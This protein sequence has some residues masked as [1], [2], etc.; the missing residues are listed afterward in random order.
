MNF[1]CPRCKGELK[2]EAPDQLRCEKE[3]LD[4][5][6]SDGVWHFL[7][8]ERESHYSRFITEY[9]AV[10]RLEGRFSGDAAY[11]RALPFQDLSGRFSADW[12]IRAAS[13]LALTKILPE[14]STILDLGAGNCW[15]SNRLSSRGH[16]VYA[17]D[18][19]TNP[20]DG[21]GAWR[22]YDAKF[23]A[24]QAEFVFL[25]FSNASVDV[26][27]FNASLHYAES[28]E[29]TFTEALRVLQP[30]GMLVVM[31]SPVY[32]DAS[33]GQKMLDERKT[34]F[35]SRYGFASDSIQSKGFLTYKRMEELGNKLGIHWQ[36]IVPF[37]GLRWAVRPLL[38]R[39]RGGREPAQFGLWLG[40]R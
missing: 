24:T 36:H 2:F 11:Y 33:S 40:R 38:A 34:Q 23:T 16:D 30:K 7:L 9:E 14:H 35:L 13:F 20:D 29:Q 12:K 19:L 18:L 21:L 26:V 17:V 22:N 8:P 37:Y 6:Q 27:I 10:R 1:V 15:L 39:L 3:A 5:H 4:F 28:Y 25:P 32:H 31:D